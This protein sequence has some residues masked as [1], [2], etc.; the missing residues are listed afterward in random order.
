MYIHI[1]QYIFSYI[2]IY[3]YVYVCVFCFS[4]SD[5]FALF[6]A[7]L[8]KRSLGSGVC[9]SVSR[10]GLEGGIMSPVVES[11]SPSRWALDC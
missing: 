6:D 3:T 4:R 8:L 9:S 11:V 7:V 2:Y 5:P 1:L 10:Q